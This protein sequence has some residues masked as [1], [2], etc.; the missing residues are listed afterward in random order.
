MSKKS[1][2][3]VLSSSSLWVAFLL[4]FVPGLGTGYIYQ[5]RWKAYWLTTIS[6]AL[7]LSISWYRE[8]TLDIADPAAIPSNQGQLL[9]L[10]TIAIFTSLEAV[11]AS[12][13]AKESLDE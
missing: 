1:D 13:K 3:Q 9:G 8:I 2:N 12:N 5:R 11:F 10:I 7:W 6:S 4:N